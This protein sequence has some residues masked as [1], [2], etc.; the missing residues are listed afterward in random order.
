MESFLTQVPEILGFPAGT[1][2]AMV[3]FALG[4]LVL[5]HLPVLLSMV[6]AFRRRGMRRRWL[7][8]GVCSALAY[9][10]VVLIAT[11]LFVPLE[12]LATY[13]MPTLNEAGY[14]DK[15]PPLR[16]M[17]LA[18]ELLWN[19]WFLA[20]PMVVAIAGWLIVSK[21]SKHWNEIADALSAT[22]AGRRSPR[23]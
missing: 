10:I 18:A 11:A 6:F 12:A 22:Q 8:V 3:L 9:G 1:A 20:W 14:Y 17:A 23:G 19:W 16:W 21:L 5:A 13:V 4:Y 15:F 2:L 7:F